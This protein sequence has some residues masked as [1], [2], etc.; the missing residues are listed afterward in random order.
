MPTQIVKQYETETAH[1][2]RNAIS[3]RCRYN[4]HGHSYKWE[5]AIKGPIHPATGMV[6]DF[7]E[8]GDIKAMIDKFDHATV[9]WEQEDPEIIDFFKT[10]FR[11]VLVMKKNVTAENMARWA[12]KWIEEWLDS[13]FNHS[14]WA[15]GKPPAF[16]QTYSCAYV[17]LWETRTG[18]AL[19]EGDDRDED[20]ILVYTHEDK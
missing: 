17:R 10:H 16:A 8:L 5:I 12:Y 9:F 13:S 6:L 3:E 4:I 18:S 15:S 7:K 1:I 14:I 2:V 20:D 11:R 19:T